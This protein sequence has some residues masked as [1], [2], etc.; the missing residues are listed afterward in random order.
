MRVSVAHVIPFE[1][2]SNDW[3]FN[4][5]LNWFCQVQYKMPQNVNQ[6][7]N[8]DDAGNS[9]RASATSKLPAHLLP[10]E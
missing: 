5:A 4:L 8:T 2:S 10:T 3:F 9:L 7:Q 6:T 1:A